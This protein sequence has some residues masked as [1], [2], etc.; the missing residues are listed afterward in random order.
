MPF[1][2][3]FHG[4][5]QEGL[6]QHGNTTKHNYFSPLRFSHL[7]S[8]GHVCLTFFGNF[9]TLI[10]KK[11]AASMERLFGQRMIYIPQFLLMLDS[12]L[13]FGLMQTKAYQIV[14]VTFDFLLA[15]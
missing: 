13:W 4:K 6:Q 11:M 5:M 9:W 1:L 15:V 10:V 12:L 8:C 3:L 14:V 7:H 2:T